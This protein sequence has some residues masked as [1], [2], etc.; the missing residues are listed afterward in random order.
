MLI[1]IHVALEAS[2]KSLIPKFI[3][4]QVQRYMRDVSFLLRFQEDNDHGFVQDGLQ[5]SDFPG[6]RCAGNAISCEV[7]KIVYTQCIIHVIVSARTTDAI[8]LYSNGDR[9]ANINN[10]CRE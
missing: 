3:C 4:A 9:T 1:D 8:S 2:E 5:S 10:R 7:Q 6:I